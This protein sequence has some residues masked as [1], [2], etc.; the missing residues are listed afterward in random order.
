M[1]TV[2]TTLSGT[3]DQARSEGRSIGGTLVKALVIVIAV[4]ALASPVWVVTHGIG[5]LNQA[6]PPYWHM[7]AGVGGAAHSSG[8]ASMGGC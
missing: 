2:P 6:P 7:N 5:Y 1:S 8:P 4:F 3:Y